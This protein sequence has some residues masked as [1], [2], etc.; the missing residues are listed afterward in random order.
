MK[1][2]L[3]SSFLFFALLAGNALAQTTGP[4]KGAIVIVGGGA[5][6]PDIWNR[7]IELAGGPANAR[8]VVIPTAGEDSSLTVSGQR[9]RKR[10]T[11]LGVAKVTVLHTRDPKQANQDAFVAPLRQATAV[12]FEGG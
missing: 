7:F 11:D 12:W 5:I 9:T 8:I 3:I 1:K 2:Q 10:L 4:D 6:S